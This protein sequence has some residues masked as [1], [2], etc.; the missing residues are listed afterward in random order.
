MPDFDSHPNAVAV[1]CGS[2]P[3]NEPAFAHAAKCEYT[4]YDGD[5]ES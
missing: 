4:G 3:G 2:S 5:W 1:F